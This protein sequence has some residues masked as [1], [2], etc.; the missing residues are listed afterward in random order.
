MSIPATSENIEKYPENNELNIRDNNIDQNTTN[1]FCF[2]N[3]EVDLISNVTLD[4]LFEP[5]KMLEPIKIIELDEKGSLNDEGISYHPFS[6]SSKSFKKSIYVQNISLSFLRNVYLIKS[7]SDS[8]QLSQLSSE[9]IS[10][11][12]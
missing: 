10:N 12:K 3:M 8:D 6:K 9:H 5:R 7:S 4:Q 2:N 11:P 1:D